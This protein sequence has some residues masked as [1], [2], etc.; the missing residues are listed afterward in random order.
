VILKDYYFLLV[1][2][3]NSGF[4]IF[5]QPLNSP[6]LAPSDYFLFPKL[7]ERLRGSHF[8]DDEEMMA[9]MKEGLAE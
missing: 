4:K 5:Q 6:D 1:L 3:H 7:K 2:F 8:S 9:S